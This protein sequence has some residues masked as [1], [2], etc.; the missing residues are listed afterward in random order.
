MPILLLINSY[1]NSCGTSLH[2]LLTFPNSIN[3]R[4]ILDLDS[5]SSADKRRTRVLGFDSVAS[6]ITAVSNYRGLP[7]RDSSSKLKNPF[8]NLLNQ[9]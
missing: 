8:L 5:P 9:R 2:R 1:V 3:L 6:L 7:V 4:C